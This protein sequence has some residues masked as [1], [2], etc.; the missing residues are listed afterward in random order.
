M[1]TSH[2]VLAAERDDASRRAQEAAERAARLA[3]RLRDLGSSAPS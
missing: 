3:A 2:E 1:R